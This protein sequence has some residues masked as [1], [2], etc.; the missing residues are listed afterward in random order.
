MP[1]S[2]LIVRRG[3][4]QWQLASLTRWRLVVRFHSPLPT[5]LKSQF[6]IPSSTGGCLVPEIIVSLPTLSDY[7]LYGLALLMCVVAY[8]QL[9]RFSH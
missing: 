7:S 4:E 1:A 3:V 5:A 9:R 8:R 2:P 6:A